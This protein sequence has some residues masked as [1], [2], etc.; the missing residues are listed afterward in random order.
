MARHRACF[1]GRSSACPCARESGQSAAVAMPLQSDPRSDC[2]LPLSKPL[3]TQP[4]SFGKRPLSTFSSASGACSSACHP[5]EIRFAVSYLA[6][7]ACRVCPLR[8]HHCALSP[9]PSAYRVCP[10]RPCTGGAPPRRPWRESCLLSS[11]RDQGRRVTARAKSRRDRHRTTSCKRGNGVHKSTQ[12]FL[13]SS[14]DEPAR[15]SRNP[16]LECALVNRACDSEGV[17]LDVRR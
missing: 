16:L 1:G 9:C 8:P 6:R 4:F 10:L 7:P 3:Q 2:A 17:R 11:F 13:H 12:R 14:S 5:S 15:Y